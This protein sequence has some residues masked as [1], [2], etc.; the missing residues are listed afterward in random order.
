LRAKVP[1][2]LAQLVDDGLVMPMQTNA[3]EEYR[4][5]TVES[6]QWYDMYRQQESELKS[7]PQRLEVFRSQEIQQYV[8]KQVAQARIIQGDVAEPR[9][10]NLE[11]G[12][13]LPSDA[14]KKLYAWAPE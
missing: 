9:T 3:G 11:F 10:I 8:R 1:K 6:Q 14:D 12:T 4:L 13:E 7:N 5:Q 2:L